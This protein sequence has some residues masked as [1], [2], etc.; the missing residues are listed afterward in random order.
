MIAFLGGVV[1]FLS[2]LFLA[3]IEKATGISIPP[4]LTLVGGLALMIGGQFTAFHNQRIKRLQALAR[5]AE[6]EGPVV[7]LS[8]DLEFVGFPFE[9][10]VFDGIFEVSIMLRFV[11]ETPAPFS[12]SVQMSEDI[13]DGWA[14]APSAAGSL[15]QAADIQR[16]PS[17]R[18][19]FF[20]FAETIKMPDPRLERVNEDPPAFVQHD[21]LLVIQMT[22]RRPVRFQR[23]RVE[24]DA[25][26]PA[27]PPCS[28]ASPP[29]PLSS[30]ESSGWSDRTSPSALTCGA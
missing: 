15:R 4:E 9:D 5:I 16:L 19:C 14:W 11:R 18:K 30:P 24:R 26:P 20:H 29:P 25:K 13:G 28:K 10:R 3:S 7:S 21:R 6:L 17:Y 27:D 12:I 23:I 8:D 1:V 2:T 22:A